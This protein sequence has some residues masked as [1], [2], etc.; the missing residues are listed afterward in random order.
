[1]SK[2][3]SYVLEREELGEMLFDEESLTYEFRNQKEREHE[4]APAGNVA[5]QDTVGRDVLEGRIRHPRLAGKLY[6]Q[7]KRSTK[8]VQALARSSV[9]RGRA[10][11]LYRQ[12]RRR[13]GY[14]RAGLLQKGAGAR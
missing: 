7:T 10:G 9:G 1:M 6:K 14:F 11:V 3:G 4:G 12:T 2:I 13:R 5:A 8:L